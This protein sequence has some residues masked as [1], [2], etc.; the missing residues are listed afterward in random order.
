MSIIYL[1]KSDTRG[2]LLVTIR[3]LSG[4]Q[5]EI[6][7]QEL[8]HDTRWEM[9]LCL[10]FFVD[11]FYNIWA[12]SES[13]LVP[14]EWEPVIEI[15]ANAPETRFFDI[16]WAQLL[17]Y[18][19]GYLVVYVKN[20]IRQFRINLN[21]F[22]ILNINCRFFNIRIWNACTRVCVATVCSDVLQPIARYTLFIIRLI[23][24]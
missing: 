8:H 23:F 24:C 14:S 9:F 13:P 10:S 16:P 1:G 18:S 15:Y 22:I 6:L 4:N 20:S 2:D 5:A 19:N 3:K 12:I 11:E 21:D 17:D 7:N